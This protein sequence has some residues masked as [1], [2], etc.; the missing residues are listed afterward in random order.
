MSNTLDIQVTEFISHNNDGTQESSF[1]YRIYDSY[2]AD[3]CNTFETL[4]EAMDYVCVENLE[5][6]LQASEAFADNLP[7]LFT[8]IYINGEDVTE[9]VKG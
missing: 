5:K 6:I 7:E 3:Y 9:E 8:A 2:G 1:G 4:E